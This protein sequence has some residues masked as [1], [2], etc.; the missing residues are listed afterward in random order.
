MIRIMDYSD[1]SNDEIFSRGMT[2]TGLEETVAE[3]IADVK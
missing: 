3:I 1:T 2:A